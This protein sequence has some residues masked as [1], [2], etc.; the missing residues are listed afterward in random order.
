M[1]LNFESLEMQKRNVPTNKIPVV[2]VKNVV[3]CLVTMFTQNINYSKDLS[4][5]LKRF[6]QAVT[7]CLLSS[8]E[9][10]KRAMFYILITIILEVNLIFT[11]SLNI[12]TS[13]FHLF[14]ELYLLI[15]LIFLFQN[16]I[17]GIPH[18]L[19]VLVSHLPANDTLKPVTT[20]I[21]FLHKLCQPLV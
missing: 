5:V 14:F 12:L 1:E 6:A 21:I 7:N 13:F 16:F 15:Y 2:D 4:V 9:R 18:L 3:N 17:I 20:D 11:I 10:T 8:A 19:Y